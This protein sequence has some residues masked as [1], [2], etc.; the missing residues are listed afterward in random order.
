MKQVAENY[1]KVRNTFKYLL[2]NLPDFDPAQH[3]V[4]FDDLQ[5]LDKYWLLRTAELADRVRGYYD[6]L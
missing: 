2:S 1:R 3:A 5:A 6:T 4:K